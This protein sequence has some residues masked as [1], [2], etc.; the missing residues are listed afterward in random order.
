[1][2]YYTDKATLETW[3]R[4]QAEDEKKKLMYELKAKNTEQE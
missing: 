3:K 4:M 1:M 2:G